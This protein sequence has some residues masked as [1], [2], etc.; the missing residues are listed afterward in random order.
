[1]IAKKEGEHQQ[2]THQPVLSREFEV[3]GNKP[4]EASFL[5]PKVFDGTAGCFTQKFIFLRK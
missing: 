1:M 4:R 5:K 3:R 2:T